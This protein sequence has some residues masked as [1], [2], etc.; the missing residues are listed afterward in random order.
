MA[1]HDLIFGIFQVGVTSP[2]SL[3]LL[4]VSGKTQKVCKV[5]H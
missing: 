5:L 2:K 4:P 1:K 3:R